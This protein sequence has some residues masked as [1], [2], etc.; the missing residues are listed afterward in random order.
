[1]KLYYYSIA[2]KEFAPLFPHTANMA[3]LREINRYK[4]TTRGILPLV[5]WAL[6]AGGAYLAAK[7]GGSFVLDTAGK[8]ALALIGLLA[9]GI[10][11]AAGKFLEATGFLLDMAIQST[12]SSNTYAGLEVIKVGWSTVRD[13]SN[14][15]FI[16]ALLYIA[17][18]TILGMGGSSTKKWVAN[19]IIAALLI[20]FSLF[21]TKIVVDAGN[22]LA[23]GFWGKMEMTVGGNN[24]SAALHLMQG[25]KIQSIKDIKDVNGNVI[26]V[27]PLNQILIY[28][29][30][31]LVMLIAGYVFLAGAVMMIVRTVTLLFLMIVSPFAFLSFA[32]PVG[33]GFGQKW[34]S[35]LIGNTF[36]APAFLAMLYL[37]IVIIN[38][39]DLQNLAG[40]NGAKWGGALAGDP[41]SFIIIYNYVLII[42]LIL[43]SL[44][45]ANSVSNGAGS[46][47][48][49]W[50]K[51]GMG[52][53]AGA[54]AGTSGAA[55]RQTAGRYGKNKMQDKDWV[56]EQNR[57]V[58]KGGWAGRTANMKLAAAQSGSKGTFDIRNAPM[59]GLGMNAA[60]AAGGINAGTGSKRNYETHG[61]VGSSII[62]QYKADPNEVAALQARISAGGADGAA[63]RIQLT[64]IKSR[65]GAS[66]RGTEKEKELIEKAKSRY[67]N[68]P[69]AQK[70]Y[71]EEMGHVELDQKRNKDVKKE[72]ERGIKIQNEKNIISNKGHID[73]EGNQKGPLLD[74]M[75]ATKKQLAALKAEGANADVAEI[76]K[77]EGILKS[78]TDKLINSV[79]QLNGKEFEDTVTPKL[80]KE[81]P[82][83]MSALGRTALM[84]VNANPDIFDQ[85]TRNQISN[86]AMTEGPEESRQYLITQAKLN[87]GYMPVNLGGELGNRSAS[88]TK[89]M[90]DLNK[91]PESEW[92]RKAIVERKDA[93]ESAVQDILGGMKPKDVA[94]LTDTA[95]GFD[96]TIAGNYTKKHLEEI[97][98]YHEKI[99]MDHNDPETKR[100]LSELRVK[101]AGGK[102]SVKDSAGNVVKNADGTDQETEYKGTTAGKA[103]MKTEEGARVFSGGKPKVDVK[104]KETAAADAKRAMDDAEKKIAETEYAA[105]GS[106][107]NYDKHNEAK[108]AHAEA[109][110]VHNKAQAELTSARSANA[111]NKNAEAAE[112]EPGDNEDG[113]TA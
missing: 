34:L 43:A 54:A 6:W 17:I 12:I 10:F 108:S 13:F 14:M 69:E 47:A 24:P 91:L 88:Y 63:A 112:E 19:L 105:T 11:W 8:A 81:H 82:E 39:I 18:K 92:K 93:H 109:E 50:A 1:M 48:G 73:A 23:M 96:D 29:G 89:E 104:A 76:E 20:N 62:S 107:F 103:Y 66:Y 74:E 57:L 37:V 3:E 101:V 36:V 90:A 85:A 45:V 31:A 22:V 106:A 111:K 30:G 97:A 113:A 52:M 68:D 60:L 72:I 9:E 80:L 95:V 102:I 70:K 77:V 94:K 35:K 110:K 15:F 26:K 41:S 25:L 55:L 99:K 87:T 78:Q 79:K 5:A 71:L 46:A 56:A 49:A 84:H 51:K 64:A 58:A 32:L 28:L 16:F 2:R 42:I 4:N 33:G 27:E 86:A 65:E 98:K 75:T 38:G 61:A 59:K 100:K 67:G 53:A 7:I 83:V 40:A 44:S 21:A